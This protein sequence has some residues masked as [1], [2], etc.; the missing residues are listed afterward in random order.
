M[1]TC[2]D[3]PAGIT[4]DYNLTNIVLDSI[5]F[6]DVSIATSPSGITLSTSN[7]QVATAMD[8]YYKVRG[9]HVG[10]CRLWW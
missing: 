7:L 9:P 3:P 2:T 6:G 5:D 10:R 4:I 1:L 8:W